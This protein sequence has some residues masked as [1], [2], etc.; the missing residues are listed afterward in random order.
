MEKIWIHHYKLPSFPD[1]PRKHE[2]A[3]VLIAL[4]DDKHC[5]GYADL[6][7]WPS[8]GDLKVDEQLSLLQQGQPTA[9]MQCTLQAARR[10]LEARAL[11]KP[12]VR[13]LPNI[14]N[15]HLILKSFS[16]PHDGERLLHQ[17]GLNLLTLESPEV[18][19][20]IKLAPETLSSTALMINDLAVKYPQICWRVDA[21]SL[22]SFDEVLGFWKQLN[23]EG[24]GKI[25]FI[26]DPCP[27]NKKHWEALESEGVS[28]AMDF[29]VANW[30]R[31]ANS[32]SQRSLFS[33]P[34]F[35]GSPTSSEKIVFVFK[36]AKQ[37]M[38]EWGSWLSKNPHRF[39]ITSYLDHPV[40]LLHAQWT[41]EI[42]SE[43][44]PRQILPCGLNLA[45]SSSALSELWSGLEQNK[46]KGNSWM[47]LI[48]SGIGY[49]QHLEA[50]QWQRLTLTV[51]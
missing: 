37:N 23:S 1:F 10:D 33:P 20:K 7:P 39:L 34:S 5:F 30:I 4:E 49:N 26:E 32:A 31:E 42:L 27:Y 51:N 24:K 18:L 3:G 17:L 38:L 48:S 44:F 14:H 22:L 50:L 15:H 35:N 40:G 29:E 28:L 21:N 12:G 9:Q 11:Q 36:P 8:M 2:G 13:F 43:Q 19:L 47:G 6:H 25:N 45:F 16:E 46:Q 41:A